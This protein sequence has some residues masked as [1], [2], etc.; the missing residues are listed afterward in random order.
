MHKGDRIAIL[1]QNCHSF[2]LLY[3]AAAAIGLIV[4]PINWRLSLEEIEYI[5]LDSG[6]RSIFFDKDYEYS[7]SELRP[8]CQSLEKFFVF[9][10]SEGDYV[11]FNELMED[12]SFEEIEVKGNDP[13]LINYTAAVQGQSRGAVMS[14]DNIVFSNIQVASMMG[15]NSYDT[16]MNVL[17]LFHIFGFSLAFS[18]MQFGGKNVIISKFDPKLVLDTIEKEQATTMGC[19]PPILDQLLNEM[20]KRNYELSSLKHIIGL[21]S[22]DTIRDFEK[23]TGS[24]FWRLYGQTE[25]TGV[26]CLCP[27]A[28]RPGSAGKQ[29]PLVNI[30]VV[31]EYDQEVETGK[32]G[33]IL[34]RSPQVFLGYWQQDELT[35]HI[36]RDGWHHT[37][38]IGC[39]DE[40]GYLWFVGRKA[41]KELIKP[42]GENVYPVEVE[43]V[44]LEHP[45]IHLVAVIGVPDPKFGEG[46]KAVCV[47]KPNARLSEQELIDFVGARIARYKKPRY[48][49]FVDSLAKK[50]DDS[51]DREKVKSIYGHDPKN[52]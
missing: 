25:T 13:Y 29:G 21:D 19:F 4:V 48:V 49:L 22:P 18:V 7:I 43:K 23:N 17:P 37:G 16:Y 47:L 27:N 8:K 32:K 30:K 33:E 5:L 52:L 35:K 12:Y 46:I 39:I 20:S 45:A 51:I 3:G 1:A 34:V 15:L 38:D 11:S 40:E 41:E 9:G 2:F 10:K 31:D 14:H 6:A 28:E 36:F 50:E 44:I 42:G 26:I 24:Q